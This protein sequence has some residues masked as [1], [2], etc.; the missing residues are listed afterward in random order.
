MF[1]DFYK[2]SEPV[3]TWIVVSFS[4][5]FSESLKIEHVKASKEQIQEYMLSKIDLEGVDVEIS[6]EMNRTVYRSCSELGGK[7]MTWVVEK[8]L[9]NDIFDLNV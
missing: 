9:E 3:Y 5:D 4:E 6:H 2:A 8:C 7:K 1:K